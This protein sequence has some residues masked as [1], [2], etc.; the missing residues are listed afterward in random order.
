MYTAGALFLAGAIVDTFLLIRVSAVPGGG[1]G[2]EELGS[3]FAGYVALASQ[4]PYP[5]LMELLAAGTK[6]HTFRNWT[7]QRKPCIEIG[8]PCMSFFMV[9]LASGIARGRMA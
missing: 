8:N 7:N 3:I 1:G 6:P 2:G 4:N 9:V 5:I